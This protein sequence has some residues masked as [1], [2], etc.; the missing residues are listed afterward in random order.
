MTL[1][2]KILVPVD[3]DPPSN[4][5][6]RVAATL[7][8]DTSSVLVL[9]HVYDANGELRAESYHRYDAAERQRRAEYWRIRLG[10][11]ESL[12]AQSGVQVE[13]CLLDGE[14]ATE[15][16]RLAREG[17]FDLIV[18][19]THGRTGACLAVL[20]SVAQTVVAAAP[21]SVLMV[22][23]DDPATRRHESSRD[24][25]PGSPQP[26]GGAPVVSIG[27]HRERASRR[28]HCERAR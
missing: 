7:A 20:G 23:A 3:F 13:T 10:S 16:A 24:I 28:V 25:V 26:H 11:L 22:R 9:V 4:K 12:V 6:V 27:E 8:R 17:Q 18:T 2:K 1:F 14:P 15:I 21:C 5:A 19:G